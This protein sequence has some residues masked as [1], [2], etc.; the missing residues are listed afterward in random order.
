MRARTRAGEP[1]PPTIGS[2]AAT[3][4]APVGGST[5][6]F[7]S[8]VSPYLPLP[9]SAEWHGNGGAEGGAAPAAGAP[10]SPPG[11]APRGSPAGQ[12]GDPGGVAGGGGA[13][14]S[15]VGE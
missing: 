11:P 12:R 13:G 7:C 14:S 9:S 3:S 1:D 2:G 5:A 4:S 8:C 6:R 15:G 10:L